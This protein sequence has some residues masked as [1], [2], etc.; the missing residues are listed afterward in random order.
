MARLKSSA[1]EWVRNNPEIAATLIGLA[2]TAFGAIFTFLIVRLYRW[3]KR[4]R[5]IDIPVLV[6][7][8]TIRTSGVEG[9][10]LYSGVRGNVNPYNRQVVFNGTFFYITVANEGKGEGSA[11][12]CH[13]KIYVPVQSKEEALK[14]G[15][16]TAWS[17]RR[18]SEGIEINNGASDDLRICMWDCDNHK[19]YFWGHF[20]E[21]WVQ[22]ISEGSVLIKIEVSARNIKNLILRDCKIR[23]TPEGPKITPL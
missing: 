19:L 7:T 11:Q 18:I 10:S 22:V 9:L 2:G 3:T 14:E 1:W 8:D 4:I 15:W 17:G 13:G 5:R 21:R 23:I 12:N 20:D 6:I 16:Q